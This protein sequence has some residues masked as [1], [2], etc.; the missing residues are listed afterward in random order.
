MIVSVIKLSFRLAVGRVRG[1][2]ASAGYIVS[3]SWA[4]ILPGFSLSTG[5]DEGSARVAASLLPGMDCV[6]TILAVQEAGAPFG[7]FITADGLFF[8]TVDGYI[9]FVQ[10]P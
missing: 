6:S 5:I 1:M 10:E 4:S 9:L 3:R 7:N 8:M 2:K